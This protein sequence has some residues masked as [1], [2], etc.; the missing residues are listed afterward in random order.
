MSIFQTG[1]PQPMTPGRAA[2]RIK[3]S[4]GQV[5]EQIE[6]SLA[7]VHEL[8]GECERDELRDALGE[9]VDAVLDFQEDLRE[10]VSKYQPNQSNVT[11]G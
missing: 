4:L 11:N 1:Q 6:A 2:E 10:L 5:F 9:D 7:Y 3:R 8:A